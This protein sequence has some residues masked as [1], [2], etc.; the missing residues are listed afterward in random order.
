MPPPGTNP[1][2]GPSTYF[3]VNPQFKPYWSS[4][5]QPKESNGGSNTS[6]PSATSGEP[7]YKVPLEVAQRKN[8][9][10]QVHV[11][12]AA[13]Y[14]HK[15]S[16]P[17]YMDS[18]EKPYAVFVFKYRSKGNIRPRIGWSLLTEFIAILEKI[19]NVKLIE[20]EIEERHRLNGLTKE[21][22]VEH[23]LKTKVSVSGIT[24]NL[25]DGF[26]ANK[27]R[28]KTIL[29]R[30]RV[31]RPL[32]PPNPEDPRTRSTSTI[33]RFRQ[34]CHSTLTQSTERFRTSRW[35][36]TMAVIRT[37][38][39]HTNGIVPLKLHRTTRPLAGT[40]QDQ[41]GRIKPLLLP[42][43]RPWPDG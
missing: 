7:L 32:I 29:L 41:V 22:L 16:S 11:S 35:L 43:M 39:L 5:K 31:Q 17:V 9:S 27:D 10:H 36:V 26:V 6:S 3:P 19:L 18:H 42:I 8:T 24:R 23:L 25:E 12:Q 15:T 1:N 34:Q 20:S 4:W 37:L 38:T 40:K 2:A 14:V 28:L 33:H 30:K 21:E 13:T